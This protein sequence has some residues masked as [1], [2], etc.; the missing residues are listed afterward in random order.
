MGYMH[1]ENLYKN[2]TI[3]MFKEC[4]AL[5]KIH[6]TSAHIK[7]DAKNRKVKFFSG[8]ENYE[9]YVSLF[10]KDFLEAKFSELYPTKNVTIYGEAYGGR[11]QGMSATYGNKLKFVGFDVIVGEDW[12]T[13]PKAEKVCLMLNIEFVDY[14]KCSTD[15]ESLNAERDKPSTQ[16]KRNGI[17]EDKIRE[18]VILKPLIE[19]KTTNGGRIVAKHKRDEFRETK[20]PRIVSDEELKILEDAKAV[21]DEWVTEMRLEHVLDKLP[22]DINVQ[23]TKLVIDA[24]IEDV[25]REAKGEIIESKE[26]TRHI[27]SKTASM[28]SQK[29][30]VEKKKS[31][32]VKVA[33]PLNCPFCGSDVEFE[34]TTFGDDMTDYFRVNCKQ[35]SHALDCWST[36]KEDAIRQWN[37][38][39]LKHS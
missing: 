25:Y 24:M 11:Q 23:H 8:G 17:I 36:T 35:N 4:Y 2:Q 1:I 7:W 10:D 15:L 32:P 39:E 14:V 19:L 31:K 30:Q 9:N 20:T 3:L 38:R 12:T 13:V 5:E 27:S 33:T 6:G 26:V 37:K 16:A 18:G 34:T 22:K 28:F 29:V 21:A